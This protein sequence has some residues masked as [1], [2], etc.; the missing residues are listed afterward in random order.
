MQGLAAAVQGIEALI[1]GEIGVRSLQE[2]AADLDA[3]ASG[4]PQRRGR[5]DAPDDGG[6][7]R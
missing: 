1:R 2:Y 7:V 4:C 6:A 3:L 5:G